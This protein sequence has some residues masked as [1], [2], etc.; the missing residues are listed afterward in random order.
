MATIPANP[1][2]R[3]RTR[4]W[5]SIRTS[6]SNI[7]PAMSST[8][9]TDSSRKTR[10]R[11]SRT[12]KGNFRLINIAYFRLITWFPS[13]LKVA[14]QLQEHDLPV[15]VAWGSPWHHKN[16]KTAIDRGNRFQEQ[17][18][19]IDEDSSLQRA[20]LRALH[21]AKWDQIIGGNEQGEGDPPNQVMIP[22]W[23]I[24]SGSGS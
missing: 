16:N 13:G 10:T 11:C 12:S 21:Q 9:S 2:T 8:T 6:W 17:H 15:H 7:T 5:P 4:T 1:W 14:V 19:R 24:F 23:S 20:I 22:F 3:Q 18:E